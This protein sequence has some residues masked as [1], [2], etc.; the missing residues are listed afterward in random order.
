MC[1]CMCIYI[2]IYMSIYIYIIVVYICVCIYICVF[3]SQ[4]RLGR[5]FILSGYLTLPLN[6]EPLPT[7]THTG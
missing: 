7:L 1:V 4:H 6:P 3:V 2:D 5:G